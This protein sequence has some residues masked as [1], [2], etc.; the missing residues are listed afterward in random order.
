MNSIYKFVFLIRFI[1]FFYS[2]IVPANSTLSQENQTLMNFYHKKYSIV[3]F[4]FLMKIMF[5]FSIAT[6][7]KIDKTERL[8]SKRISFKTKSL[9][10]TFTES[11]SLA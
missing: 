9:E 7:C 4:P 2:S 6:T 10:I 11:T 5:T 1:Q 3:L 8:I